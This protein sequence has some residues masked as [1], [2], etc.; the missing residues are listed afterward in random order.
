[1][2]TLKLVT[3]KVLRSKLQGGQPGIS[4]NG[5]P[6]CGGNSHWQA[7]MDC[8]PKFKRLPG[9]GAHSQIAIVDQSFHSTSSAACPPMTLGMCLVR[10]GVTQTVM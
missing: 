3:T 1:M 9:P 7:Q 5:Q 10:V 2:K 8:L 4:G 6:S